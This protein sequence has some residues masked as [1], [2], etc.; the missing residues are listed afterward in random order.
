MLAREE[1]GN[2]FGSRKMKASIRAKE[3][4]ALDIAGI[5]ESTG[6][7]IRAGIPVVAEVREEVGERPHIP[8]FNVC[9]FYL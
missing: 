4:N 6:Q 3:A 2:A 8:P 7:A 1:L 5:M 9:V